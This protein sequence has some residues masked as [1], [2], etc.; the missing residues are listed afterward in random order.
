MRGIW[1]KLRLARRGCVCGVH[2]RKL[3]LID[4]THWYLSSAYRCDE[5]F[6]CVIVRSCLYTTSMW[7]GGGVAVILP[8]GGTVALQCDCE[9]N[10]WNVSRGLARGPAATRWLSSA[11]PPTHITSIT[12]FRVR[13]GRLISRKKYQHSPFRRLPALTPKDPLY[14]LYTVGIHQLYPPSDEF[15]RVSIICAS[16]HRTWLSHFGGAGD[17]TLFIS[18]LTPQLLSV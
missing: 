4:E 11:A 8:I 5:L 6:R 15:L 18:V 14:P 10:S 17:V 9:L 7:T 3:I 13:Q 1:K 2:Y 12:C 16:H